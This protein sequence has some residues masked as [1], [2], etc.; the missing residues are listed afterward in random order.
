MA[1]IPADCGEL[2]TDTERNGNVIQDK[3]HADSFDEY[4]GET[5]DPED[6]IQDNDS[7]RYTENEPSHIPDVVE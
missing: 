7:L 4:A 1:R 5:Q 3:Q 6:F 2:M